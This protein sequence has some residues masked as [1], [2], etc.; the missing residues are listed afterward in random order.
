MSDRPNFRPEQVAP[1][2]F[3]ADGAVVL[4]D[5]TLGEQ[6]SVWF[7]AVLRGDVASIRIGS[8]TNIQDGCVLHADE[9]FPCMLGDDVTVG[10]R[11]I[12][13]GCTIEDRVL[14]GMGAIVMNGAVIGHD[15][16]VAVGAVVPEGMHVPPNSLAIGLPAKVRRT[17]E[18]KDHARIAHAAEHYVRNAER[19]RG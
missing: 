9:G 11:A 6:S 2:A 10:H 12:V 8:R 1:S 19:Y 17:L 15:S 3:I 13:H 5:V 18:A 7:Q 14:I 4:G 16:I